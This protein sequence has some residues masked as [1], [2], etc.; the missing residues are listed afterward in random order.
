MAKLGR[1]ERSKTLFARSVLASILE[2]QPVQKHFY[3]DNERPKPP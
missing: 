3:T 2:E 1:A